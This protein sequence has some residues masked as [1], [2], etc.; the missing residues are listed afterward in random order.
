MIRRILASALL[1]ITFS[2]CGEQAAKAGRRPPRPVAP[3]RANLAAFVNG[4]TIVARTGELQLSDSALHAFDGDTGT[5]WTSPP[6]DFQHSA[7]LELPVAATVSAVT[8]DLSMPVYA[9]RPVKEISVDA[10][11]DGTTFT[12]VATLRLDRNHGRQRFVVRPV[13]ANLLRFTTRTNF[14][15][16]RFLAVPEIKVEGVTTG[17]WRKPDISGVW[18]VH[19]DVLVLQQ[20]GSR[21]SGFLQTAAA[22]VVLEGG[23]NGRILCLYWM[24]KNAFGIAA[25]TASSDGSRMSGFVWDQKAILSYFWTTWFGSKKSGVEAVP[26]AAAESLLERHLRRAGFVP[27]YQVS[28]DHV[29]SEAISEIVRVVRENPAQ[30]FRIVVRNFLSDDS[31]A[32]R[33]ASKQFA[34]ALSAELARAGISPARLPVTAAGDE[35]LGRKWSLLRRTIQT[36]AEL[37]V[38]E[39][40]R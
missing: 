24:Q 6:G 12:P 7:D 10:S 25:L 38:V 28:A 30:R 29:T 23:W 5:T 13:H 9:A 37:E 39:T 33:E 26:A 11:R 32:N 8:I 36:R 35:R 34:S 1:L 40:S 2:S 3:Q 18:D 15:D 21:V 16:R 14:G 19:G 27:L 17:T 4:A 22:P 20:S 31:A